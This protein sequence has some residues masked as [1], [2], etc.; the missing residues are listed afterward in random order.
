ME[1]SDALTELSELSSQVKD[2]A[3]LGEAGVVLASSG[4]RERGEELGRIA[5]EL[6]EAA[7]AVRPDGPSVTRVEVALPGG[8]LVVVR[9]GDRTAVA[10][11]VAEPTSGLVVYDLRT[12]LRRIDEQTL[13]E[14]DE[15]RPRRRRRKADPGA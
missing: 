5:A 12:A 11:T 13:P 15:P 8:S 10:T 3:I 6:L 2:V 7:A 9:E 4:E 1:P 14:A